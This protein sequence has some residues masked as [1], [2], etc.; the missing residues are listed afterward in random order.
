M[1]F[2]TAEDLLWYLNIIAGAWLVFRLIRQHLWP[3]YRFLFAYLLC[4][5]AQQIA[6]LTVRA[7]LAKPGPAYS[8]IYF[9][10][11]AVKLVLSVFIVLELYEL[12][13]S[14]HG[15]I[16]AYGKKMA[17][18]ALLAVCALAALQ[19]ILAPPREVPRV[20]DLLRQYLW[21][22]E[23]TVDLALLLLLL[24]MIGF[25]T[26]FPVKIAKNYAYYLG[27]FSTYFLARW[28]GLF[29]VGGFPQYRSAI[30][31]GELCVS[32]LCVCGMA[33]SIRPEGEH[34]TIAPGHAWNQAEMERLAVQLKEIN[35]SLAHQR[36]RA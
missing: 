34:Q 15:A 23:R 21:A 12:S 24:G 17:S 19:L 5:I 26:W 4:D 25:L 20:N 1:N 14:S 11:Q 9:G 18:Y 2:S 16:A 6:G 35:A 29:A 7:V 22:Y 27:G 31:L 3:V 33:L 32:L 28:I 8:D 10:G 36:G 30:S 13:L